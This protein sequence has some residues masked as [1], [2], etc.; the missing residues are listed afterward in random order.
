MRILRI[1]R[2]FSLIEL[3][4]VIVI[5]AILASLA[6]PAFNQITVGLDFTRAQGTL[7]AELMQA[8]QIAMSRNRNVAVRLYSYSD[9]SAARRQN[10]VQSYIEQSGIWSPT[11]KLKRLPERVCIDEGATLS[12]LLTKQTATTGTLPGSLTPCT[13]VT[14]TF[15]PD[16]SARPDFGQEMFLTL[17]DARLG[18]SSSSLPTNYCIVQIFPAGGHVRAYRP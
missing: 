15:R 18:A 14:V 8:R 6:L 12:P 17:R 11:G 7:V 9:A 2:G 3:L 5:T 16:G 4:V 13:Y 10:A 1:P